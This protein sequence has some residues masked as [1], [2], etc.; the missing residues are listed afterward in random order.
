MHPTKRM[1]STLWTLG[2]V[3]AAALVFA[4]SATANDS[5]RSHR[6]ERINNHLD[7][8]AVVAALSGDAF[9]AARLDARGDRIEHRYDH[10]YYSR[11][12][13]NR[14]HRG[15]HWR[16]SVR[17]HHRHHEGCGHRISSHRWGHKRHAWRNS[18]HNR[19]DRRDRH[20]G[21]RQNRHNKR[22]HRD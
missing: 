1:N 11:H 2:A 17:K 18:H 10:R 13:R 8:L 4:G 19:H 12:D 21:R 5:H 14:D 7:F 6:G 20:D 16:R 22:G 3:M 9:L 15:N